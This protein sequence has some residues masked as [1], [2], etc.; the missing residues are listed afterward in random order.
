MT[1]EAY[2]GQFPVT[3]R[4]FPPSTTAWS[5][6]FTNSATVSRR[7]RRMS[8]SLLEAAIMMLEYLT[9][10]SDGSPADGAHPPPPVE[11]TATAKHLTKT[12]SAYPIHWPFDDFVRSIWSGG[13]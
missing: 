12:R 8:G 6:A 3:P 4:S 11:I 10:Y 13:F 1:D 2:E 7:S 5:M 9:E